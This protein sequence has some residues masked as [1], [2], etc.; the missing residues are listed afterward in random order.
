MFCTGPRS[1][2]NLVTITR[3]GSVLLFSPG[4]DFT[5]YDLKGAII[6][7]SIIFE[8][9]HYCDTTVCHNV[10]HTTFFG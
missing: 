5:K 3:S 9:R 1:L 7:E 10:N 8:E 2:F 6:F 4:K